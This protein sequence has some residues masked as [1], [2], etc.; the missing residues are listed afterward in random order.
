[1]HSQRIAACISKPN[2]SRICPNW[3][4]R[5]CIQCVPNRHIHIQV[6]VQYTYLGLVPRIVCIRTKDPKISLKPTAL[7]ATCRDGS[8]QKGG[9]EREGTRTRTRRP[10]VKIVS[11]SRKF[12][13]MQTCCACDALPPGLTL[14]IPSLLLYIQCNAMHN[15]YIIYIEVPYILYHTLLLWQNRP[16]KI[17]IYCAAPYSV[18][19]Q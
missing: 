11:P 6:H 5:P 9:R 18:F 3:H 4:I 19:L 1:M 8:S 2:E 12:P 10:L 14:T 7:D 17:F 13:I 15:A 16:E